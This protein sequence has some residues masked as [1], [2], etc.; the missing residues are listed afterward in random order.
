[1]ANSMI[2]TRNNATYRSVGVWSRESGSDATGYDVTNLNNEIPAQTWRSANKTDPIKVRCDMGT[3][4][5]PTFVAIIGHN[6]SGGA[7]SFRGDTNN[8]I[9]GSTELASISIPTNYATHPTMFATFSNSTARRYYHLAIND[10]SAG[11]TAT[12]NDSYYEIG[13]I[14]IGAWEEFTSDTTLPGNSAPIRR[15][16]DRQLVLHRMQDGSVYRVKRG[17]SRVLQLQWPNVPSAVQATLEALH[18]ALYG[19]MESFCVIPNTSDPLSCHYGFFDG[20]LDVTSFSEGNYSIGARFQE[21]S[22]GESV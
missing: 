7:V 2:Y 12:S 6:L 4:I 13:E 20:P 10:A 8:S 19:G 11:G 9:A 1:M 3:T 5:T 22:L 16:T 14:V 18:A 15:T 17:V 21:D